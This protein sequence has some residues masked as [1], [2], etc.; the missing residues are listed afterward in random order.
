MVNA[1][2]IGAFRK[3]GAEGATH[4]VQLLKHPKEGV[5]CIAA[6]GLAELGPKAVA[7][8]ADIVEIIKS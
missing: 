4:L 1:R 7:V 8:I 5:R 6:P 3:T 2:A